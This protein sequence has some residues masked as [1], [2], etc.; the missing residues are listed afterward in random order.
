[1]ED[2]VIGINTIKHTSNSG[3]IF[4]EHTNNLEI[5]NEPDN[6]GSYFRYL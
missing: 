1:M 3:L 5:I 2:A 6:S 4:I